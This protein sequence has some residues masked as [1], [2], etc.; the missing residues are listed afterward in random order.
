M[1]KTAPN[2]ACTRRWGFGAVFKQFSGFEFFPLPNI[3]HARPSAGNANRWLALDG[4][5]IKN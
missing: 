1:N 4:F 2:K 3:I 5:I